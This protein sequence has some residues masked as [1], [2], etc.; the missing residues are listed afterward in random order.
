MF[1][2]QHKKRNAER[3]PSFGRAEIL[4]V[5]GR[6]IQ[7]CLIKEI[8]Q[9]G[10]YIITEDPKLLPEACEV[11]I[12]HLK[13]TVKAHVRWRKKNRAGLE[14]DR[15]VTDAQLAGSGDGWETGT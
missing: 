11:W 1:G 9:T 8:S 10:A 4:D 2:R 7:E 14:F 5:E 6:P 3:Y 12:P 13:L 15:P